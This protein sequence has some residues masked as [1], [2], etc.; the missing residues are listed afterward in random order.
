[1]IITITISTSSSLHGTEILQRTA[2]SCGRPFCFIEA[3]PAGSGAAQASRGPNHPPAPLPSCTPVETT[4]RSLTTTSLAIQRAGLDLDRHRWSWCQ[5]DLSSARV[6]AQVRRRLEIGARRSPAG[7]APAFLPLPHRRAYLG[8]CG[9]SAR[10]F[11]LPHTLCVLVRSLCHCANSHSFLS[12]S[13]SHCVAGTHLWTL[14]CP[15]QSLCCR[16]TIGQ[17][18]GTRLHCCFPHLLHSS[19]HTFPQS[20]AISFLSFF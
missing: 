6:T 16:D 15:I 11:F 12:R 7:N 10:L 5:R 8:R 4:V 19:R 1:M 20:F 9:P 13:L 3:R 18:D 2:R 14:F 17:L